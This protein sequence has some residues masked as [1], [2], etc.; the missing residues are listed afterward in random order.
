M[1]N[2]DVDSDH[3]L[4]VA[5]MTLK[6]RNAKIG[7]ARNQRPGIL[8]LKDTFIKEKYSI[9]LRDLSSIL[10]D[11]AAL[12]NDDFNTAVIESAIDD[13]IHKDQIQMYLRR[14]IENNRREV[15][16][17]EEGIRLQVT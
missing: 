13:Q 16:V 5:R 8:W 17:D 14:Y 1:R 10:Q 12:T 15:T 2:A 9:R 6:L 11:E 3:K 4:L 7:M